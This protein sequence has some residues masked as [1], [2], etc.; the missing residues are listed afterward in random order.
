MQRKAQWR[1]FRADF[2]TTHRTSVCDTGAGCAAQK[3]SPMT[4]YP[5]LPPHPGQVPATFGQELVRGL[6]HDDP[7]LALPSARAFSHLLRGSPAMQDRLL[8]Q[9]VEGPPTTGGPQRLILPALV[10]RML[11]HFERLG[12]CG[13][14]V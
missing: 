3:T 13:A 12:A 1:P 9:F 8:D 4:A 7:T 10:A 6:L 11:A 14:R 5:R 2:G